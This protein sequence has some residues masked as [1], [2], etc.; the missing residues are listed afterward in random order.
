MVA[1]RSNALSQIQ[2]EIAIRIPGHWVAVFAA[3]NI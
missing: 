2:V 3:Y 1:K